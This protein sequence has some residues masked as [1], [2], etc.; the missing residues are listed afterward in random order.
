MSRLLPVVLLAGAVGTLPLHAQGYRAE[1]TATAG[2]LELRPL[3]RDSLPENQVPGE[4]L[5]RRLAD[6][7]VVS[8][9]PGRWCRW[10][11][12]A[13]VEG[14]SVASQEL[15]L[16][17]WPG[18]QGLSGHAH[19]RSRYGT[20]AFWPGSAQDFEVV[21]AYLSYDRGD[22]RVRAGRQF[23]VDG[24]GYYNFDGLALLWRGLEPLRL[25]AYGGWSLARGLNAP[26]TGVLLEEA[27]ALPPDDR[28]LIFGAELGAHHG[29][30]LSGS[31]TY[32]RE[33]RTDR[34]ALYSERVALD[35]R[36]LVG[37][38]VLDL[39]A[40]YDVAFDQVNE[41]RLRA[42]GPLV[43]TLDLSAE[44]R[45][46]RPFFE[47]WTIWGAFSPI[48]FTEG[49]ASLGWTAASAG[50]RLEAGGAYRD[51]EETGG[52][53]D[54]PG[55]REDGWRAF[56][57]A[58]WARDTWFAA[59][60]YRAEAG[61]GAA[62][63]GGDAR[64]GRRF[65]RGRTVSV[66]GS[67]THTFG[68]FR[69]GEQRMAG[70]VAEAAWRF[71]ALSL[72]AGAGLY[73]LTFQDRA[74]SPDWTQARLHAGLSYRFGTEIAARS[75]PATSPSANAANRVAPSKERSP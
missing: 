52:G 34:L 37:A 50:L 18:V 1:L 57:R 67:S 31:L 10:Y 3:A 14:I 75:V 28:G 5:R 70:A 69:L 61:P 66:R 24:L 62:R 54:F 65:G 29:R 53:A 39:S 49:R 42:S 73:R 33:I 41:A 6:G 43:S 23:R 74:G 17:A 32:Q 38:A 13:D 11:R 26:R 68:E 59:A 35:G 45:H 48:G 22:A 46:Y 12:T 72:T 71:G 47:L 2:Y 15:R 4:G 27:E 16:A 55:L 20:D 40:E 60:A 58:D 8:C 9:E 44:V 7:T 63:F 30:H 51:Y 36:T 25:E 21:S 19:L 56:G 64:A